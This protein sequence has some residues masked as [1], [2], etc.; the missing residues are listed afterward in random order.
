LD[1]LGYINSSGCL[2]RGNLSTA[3]DVFMR[4][5]STPYMKSQAFLGFMEC[6]FWLALPESAKR[7]RTMIICG[8]NFMHFSIW[9]LADFEKCLYLIR[10]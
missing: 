6:L 5:D 9:P 8:N 3:L 2:K 4:A 1:V 7:Y 10:P